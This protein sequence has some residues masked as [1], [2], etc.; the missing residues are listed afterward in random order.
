MTGKRIWDL[1]GLR[2]AAEDRRAVVVPRSPVWGKP[3]PARFI[4]NMIASVVHR[5]LDNG[6]YIYEKEKKA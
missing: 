1:E 3:R 2:A 5:L 6:M 4:Y